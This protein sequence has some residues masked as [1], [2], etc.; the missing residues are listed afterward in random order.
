MRSPSHSERAEWN[1]RKIR[2]G[3]R[4]R[5]SPEAPRSATR[6]YPTRAVSVLFG[7]ASAVA[8]VALNGIPHGSVAS[9]SASKAVFAVLNRR[10]QYPQAEVPY[11][12]LNER[13]VLS[14]TGHVFCYQSTSFDSADYEVIH[15]SEFGASSRKKP[16][17]MSADAS[18]VAFDDGTVMCRGR[19]E[20]GQLGDGTTRD[21]SGFRSVLLPRV[22]GDARPQKLITGRTAD[23]R[24][25]LRVDGKAICWGDNTD[26]FLL[27]GQPRLVTP[28]VINPATFG[29]SEFKDMLVLGHYDEALCFAGR[30][31]E[32]SCRYQGENLAVDTSDIPSN[33]EVSR[34]VGYDFP[35]RPG[36]L[37]ALTKLSGLYCVYDPYSQH[38]REYMWE[39]VSCVSL[40]RSRCPV[41][42]GSVDV[43]VAVRDA[44]VSDTTFCVITS[45]GAVLCRGDGYVRETGLGETGYPWVLIKFDNQDG[46]AVS[47]STW[48]ADTCGGFLALGEGFT[49]F[50][51]RARFPEITTWVLSGPTATKRA[52]SSNNCTYNRNNP[53]K[54]QTLNSG[55]ATLGSAPDDFV[56]RYW[57][58][59]RQGKSVCLTDA[60]V[61][62]FGWLSKKQ[63]R[64]KLQEYLTNREKN[65][66]G[67][68]NV[69]FRIMQDDSRQAAVWTL[70]ENGSL[71][72]NGKACFGP[73]AKFL[74]EIKTLDSQTTDARG[75]LISLGDYRFTSCPTRRVNGI[76]QPI[77]DSCW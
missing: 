16:T 49:D 71:K 41:K 23:F 36:G 22:E 66:L 57:S 13:C 47:F 73:S 65:E 56:P 38:D 3:S 39:Y 24:C 63:T 59:A 55:L 74:I 7:V 4:G 31:R 54:E 51:G 8:A 34:L 42:L 35:H 37:C 18:C 30:S 77:E 46:R 75:I 67:S 10:G 40:G 15:P 61:P 43:G 29:V 11:T 62:D 27:P 64:R 48:L 9:A 44:L 17:V 1:M 45:T 14:A 52:N 53:V 28:S 50:K 25:L 26:G 68:G 60:Y 20:S 6:S 5:W 76:S 12:F 72:R 2:W 21:S 69:S 32:V 19:N 70:N 33:D 58:T